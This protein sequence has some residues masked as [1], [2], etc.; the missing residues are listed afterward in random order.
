MELQ[1]ASRPLSRRQLIQGVGAVGLALSAGA[2]LAGCSG[3]LARAPEPPRRVRLG[4]LSPAPPTGGQARTHEALL[5]GLREYGYVEGQNLVVERRYADGQPERLPALAAE[6]VALPVDL[7]I[8][9]GGSA[10]AAAQATSTIPIVAPTS[11]L[12]RMGLAA[13]LARPG[14]NVTGTTM[15]ASQLS[16]KRLELLKETIPG[17]SRVAAIGV[18]ADPE[19]PT[20][21]HETQVAAGRLGIAVHSLEVGNASDLAAAFEAAREQADAM[22]AAGGG[23]MARHVEQISA[24]ALQHKL[25]LMGGSLGFPTA[26]SLMAYASSGTAQH[27][28]AAYYV[29]R[30]LKGARPGDLPIEQPMLFDFIINL[31]TAQALGLEIPRRVLLQATEVI[32]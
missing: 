10:P 5:A 23:P 15:L 25:P 21:L 22:L 7:I 30:I 6:L 11:D 31:R 4:W 2:V 8:A 26:G 18:A 29:D 19:W 24:L 3:A 9:T 28:R 14:G 20:T 32:E 27:R 1:P 13:S 12:V 17:L 16:G